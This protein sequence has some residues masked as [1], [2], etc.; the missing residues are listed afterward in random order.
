WL[1]EKSEPRSEPT[2]Q[3]RDFVEKTLA[4]M[5]DDPNAKARRL[6]ESVCETVQYCAIE[7]GLGGWI[8]HSAGEVHELKYGDCKDKANYLHTLLKVA[9]VQSRT[10]TIF[11]HNGLPRPF[12]L[13]T[14]GGNFNHEI[15]II[16]LP[17]GP[18][19]SDPTSRTTPFGDLPPSDAEAEL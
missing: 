8:P 5:P 16:D 9:K 2:P 6:Y 4:G 18:V 19:L 10:A 17:G 15:L 7:L 12:G 14:L 13:P 3:I 11:A 1:Y